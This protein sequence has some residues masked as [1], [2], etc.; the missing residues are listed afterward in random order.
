MSD[1]QVLAMVEELTSHASQ[2]ERD[3]REEIARADKAEA[4]RDAAREGALKQAAD[5]AG[6]WL[7]AFLLRSKNTK[8][9]E[10]SWVVACN[11]LSE[12][13]RALLTADAQPHAAKPTPARLDPNGTA[14]GKTRLE[15]HVT[16]PDDGRT[17]GICSGPADTYVAEDG[18][19][20]HLQEPTPAPAEQAEKNWSY[21]VDPWMNEHYAVAGMLRSDLWALLDR[22]HAAGVAA[23]IEMAARECERLSVTTS[24]QAAWVAHELARMI[25]AIATG[26]KGE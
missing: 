8:T 17:R 6:D 7:E 11:E 16:V 3:L 15:T 1:A 24:A 2:L 19:R 21:L 20:I 12:S 23:G 4:E 14:Q 5:R 18:T 22:T 25:R 10:S 9:I 13:I 26:G